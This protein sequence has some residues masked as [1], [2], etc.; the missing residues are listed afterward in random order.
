M[1]GAVGLEPS[2]L[3]EGSKLFI[4]RTDRNDKETPKRGTRRVHG[5]RTRDLCR[6]KRVRSVELLRFT[7]TKI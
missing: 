3:L 6:D 7:W 5:T 1:A 2:G 4:L